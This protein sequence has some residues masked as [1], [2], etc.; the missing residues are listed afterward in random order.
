MGRDEQAEVARAAGADLIV[1][2]H[3]ED[4]SQAVRPAT[5]GHWVD[6]I[7][8]VDLSANVDVAVACLARDGVVK[9]YL[10]ETPQVRLTIPF[11]PTL[12]AV[13]R[14]A[15]SM[16]TPCR[17][18]RCGRRPTR[19]RPVPPRGHMPHGIAQTYT[20]DEVAEA[21]EFQESGKPVGKVLLRIQNP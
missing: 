20:L 18:Q 12:M 4:V 15:S 13:S 19:F 3:K 16:S 5:G 1:N 6:R 7:V 21:H 17:K 11:F 14:S 8:D 10:T 2:R 9:A